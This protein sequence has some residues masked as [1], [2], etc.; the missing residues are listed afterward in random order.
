MR[1]KFEKN[2]K[3]LR[4]ISGI[5]CIDGFRRLLTMEPSLLPYIKQVPKMLNVTRTLYI[6]S[7]TPF[8]NIE[9]D[10][11]EKKCAEYLEALKTSQT[12]C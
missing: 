4:F 9:K 12:N 3:A 2:T 10:E 11:I 8:I 5:C 7:T 1:S 6:S